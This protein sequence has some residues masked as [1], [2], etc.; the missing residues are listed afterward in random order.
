[1]SM[2]ALLE[3]ELAVPSLLLPGPHSAEEASAAGAEGDGLETV[4]NGNDAS[5]QI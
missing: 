5:D 1:M 3:A 4:Q 2:A